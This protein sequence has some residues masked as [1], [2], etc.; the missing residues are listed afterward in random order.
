V[1]TLSLSSITFSNHTI[2]PPPFQTSFATTVDLR[3]ATNLLVAINAT[4]NTSTGLLTWTFTSLDPLTN[5]PPTDPTVGFLPPGGDGGVLFSVTPVQGLA[6]NTQISNQA[7]IVFDLNPPMSTATWSNALDNTAPTSHVLALPSMENAVSFPVTW[8]GTDVGAGVQDYNI[9]ASDNGS[10]FTA[11][12]SN[13]ASTSAIYTGQPGH[14]YRFFSIARDLVGNVEMKTAAAEATTSVPANKASTITSAATATFSF[15]TA[16]S[17]TVTPT[18]F[19]VATITESGAL[20][21]GVMFVDNHNGT[22]T[23]SGTATTAG[24]F[25]LTLSAA[26]GVGTATQPFTLTVTQS[27]KHCKE[28]DDDCK[29]HR[30]RDDRRDHGEHDRDNHDREHQKRDIDD[31][32]RR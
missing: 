19:P 30:D 1:A 11:F 22:A 28:E 18:G 24:T 2:V 27:T 9:Y 14:T 3:P 25:P 15:G 16:A 31:E 8:S 10:P 12:Q 6:T 29:H 4:L 21:A 13:T 26:N 23:L 20:P 7:T 32:S 5:Q 17:F